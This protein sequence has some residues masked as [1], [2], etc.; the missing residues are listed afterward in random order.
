MSPMKEVQVHA[1]G[2]QD[3]TDLRKSLMS[4]T[5][6]FLSAVE[7]IKPKTSYILLCLERR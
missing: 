6:T 7:I 1:L 3:E 4:S 2:E 5:W